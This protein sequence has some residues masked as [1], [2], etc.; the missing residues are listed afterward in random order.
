M[1]KGPYKTCSS[2]R[3]LNEQWLKLYLKGMARINQKIFKSVKHKTS[4][5]RLR[6]WAELPSYLWRT[7]WAAAVWWG[8]A[9]VPPWGG[10]ACWSRNALSGMSSRGQTP[11]TGRWCLQPSG[12]ITRQRLSELPELQN[13]EQ[14]RCCESESDDTPWRLPREH[15]RAHT[16][17]IELPR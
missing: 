5:V 11:D 16:W 3:F 8:K 2:A 10:S 4:I 12:R 6:T 13:T 15:E 14:Q 17:V 7:W 1:M 9:P